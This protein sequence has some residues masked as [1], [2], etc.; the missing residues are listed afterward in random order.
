MLQIWRNAFFFKDFIWKRET[1]S[2]SRG[3]VR[4]EVTPHWAGSLTQGSIPGCQ[5]HDLSQRQTLNQL[6]HPGAPKLMFKHMQ[7]SFQ[8]I[9][10]KMKHTHSKS[11]SNL[12]KLTYSFQWPH[13]Q[14]VSSALKDGQAEQMYHED[15]VFYQEYRKACSVS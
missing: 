14:V 15:Q 3:R 6:S 5:D 11:I 7:T 13:T 10:F 12:L 9:I 2:T 4:G 8:K 1:K